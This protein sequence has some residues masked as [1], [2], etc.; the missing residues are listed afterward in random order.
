MD[1][2]QPLA[3]SPR[4]SELGL[5]CS[6][7][8]GLWIGTVSFS[9]LLFSEKSLLFPSTAYQGDVA[10][11]VSS[12]VFVSAMVG[13]NEYPHMGASFLQEYRRSFP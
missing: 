8:Q 9:F 3:G 11:Y 2:S 10:R 7:S 6:H 13:I 5:C 4:L 1:L 12:L